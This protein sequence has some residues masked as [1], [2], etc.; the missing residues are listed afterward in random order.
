MTIEPAEVADDESL[1]WEDVL[2]KPQTRRY[3][4]EFE[5]P[6]TGEMHMSF[7]PP[8]SIKALRKGEFGKTEFV[9]RPTMTE[10]TQA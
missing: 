5:D 3:A 2:T 9:T 6:W 7:D 4:E 10:Y 1:L 8:G